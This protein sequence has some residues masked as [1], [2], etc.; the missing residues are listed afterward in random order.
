MDPQ[1]RR[2]FDEHNSEQL[3]EEAKDN[4]VVLIDH[5]SDD[6]DQQYSLKPDPPTQIA[7][8]IDGGT[9]VLPV[10]T[11]K[12]DYP[13]TKIEWGAHYNQFEYIFPRTVDG[14]PLLAPSNLFLSVFPCAPLIVD[15]KTGIAKQQDFQASRGVYSFHLS[16]LMCK[17]KLEY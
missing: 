12:V 2:E 8:S 5:D 9:L 6:N 3:N 16:D 1:K 7:L 13:P 15:R 10:Q 14:K 17:G 11:K 4:V